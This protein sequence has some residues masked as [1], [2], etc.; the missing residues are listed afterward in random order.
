MSTLM[1]LTY[2]VPVL[3]NST[4]F[5]FR[6]FTLFFQSIFFRQTTAVPRTWYD[7]SPA[8]RGVSRELE[9][10]NDTTKD[11]A[12]ANQKEGERPETR[13][14]PFPV[15]YDEPRYVRVPGIDASMESVRIHENG[16]RRIGRY[17]VYHFLAFS[18]RFHV[19]I[20]CVI[21]GCWL[22]IFV[23]MTPPYIRIPYE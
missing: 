7:T 17:Q 9:L 2:L 23:R 10:T 20:I 18:F 4:R 14:R 5:L 19:L 1:L 12:L 8:Q 16:S 11:R 22:Y 6:G 21:T 15:C 13:Q 3:F